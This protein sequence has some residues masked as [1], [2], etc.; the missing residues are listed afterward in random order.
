MLW[1]S[2][3]QGCRYYESVGTELRRGRGCAASSRIQIKKAACHGFCPV[4]Q[5]LVCNSC[6]ASSTKADEVIHV[7]QPAFALHRK[8]E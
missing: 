1:T 5:K 7:L 3:S 6:M 2:K 4:P 8:K